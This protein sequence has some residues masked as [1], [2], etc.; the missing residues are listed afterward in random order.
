VSGQIDQS[1]A[2]FHRWEPQLKA[3]AWCDPD[4][5]RGNDGV[6]LGVKDVYDTAGIPTEYGSAVFKGRVPTRTATVVKSLL[7]NGFVLFGKTVTAELAYFAPG[8]TTNPWAST[9]TPGGSSMGSAAA[10]AA[11][12]VPAAIGTQT[13]GSMIRP[14]AFCGVVGFKPTFGRLPTTGVLRFAPSLDTLGVFARTV[15]MCGQLAAIMAGDSPLDE[16]AKSPRIGVVR[17][18]EWELAEPAARVSLETAVGLLRERG[19]TL[20]EMEM[21]PRLAYA[22]PVLRVIMSAE[23]QRCI[24]PKIAHAREK[25]SQQLLSLLDDGAKLTASEY[26]KARAAQ[27][28]LTDEFRS[29]A[30]SVDAIATLATLGEAPPVA[31][32][33]DP[34]CCT[35]WTLVGAPALTLPAGL[36]P[37]RLPLGLQLVGRRKEDAKLIATARWV[38]A[39]L[40]PIGE[41]PRPS[42]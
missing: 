9:R 23:A 24:G 19:A 37:N 11:G 18:P 40:P 26:R 27:R 35:R 12:V 5:L 3:F 39:V 30:E 34:R 33:G 29:W 8:P 7:A 32:T 1:I 16:I 21:P 28:K 25:I 42:N 2:Q 20:V 36:G 31:T 14:A 22:I 6:P 17:S 15:E 38:E 41:P 4:R 13:N 10:V